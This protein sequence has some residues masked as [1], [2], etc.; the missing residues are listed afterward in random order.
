MKRLAFIFFALLALSLSAGAQ[1][2]PSKD[3][4]QELSDTIQVR[5]N[6]HFLVKNDFTFKK[7]VK[8]DKE[9]KVD[10][11]FSA[12][13][14]YFP[15]HK[16]DQSWFREMVSDELKNF[17]TDYS[18][19]SIFARNHKVTEY[20]THGIGNDG[21]PHSYRH[22]KKDPRT[23][24]IRFISQ[25]GA[26]LYPKGLTDRYIAVWQSHGLFYDDKQNFWRFQ[27]A[28]LFRTV[29]DMFTQS[30]VLPFLIPMLENSGAYVLTPRER[31]INPLEFVVDND[32]NFGSSREGMIR[33]SGTYSES[34]KWSS[35][36]EGFADYKKAYGF[37][38]KPFSAG[39]AR[40]ASCAEHPNASVTWTPEISQRGQYAVYISYKTVGNSTR[41]AHY[42]VKH[43]GGSTEF[44]VNQRRGGGTWIYLGTFE[45]DGDGSGSVTL[46]NSGN[47]GDVVTADAVR[48]GGGMGKVARGGSVSGAKSYM[49]GALYSEVWAG[50]DSAVTRS[51]TTEYID[52]YSTRGAWTSWMREEKLIPF[53]LA[54]AFHTDAGIAQNDSIIGTLAI[55]T[56]TSEGKTTFDDGRDRI[57][58]RQLC[59]FV[60]TQVVEDLRAQ[61]DPLWTR[62]GIWDKSYNESRT[63]NV[64]AMI[65]ELM[66]HQNFNDMK[67]GLDPSFRFTV[68]RAVYKGVLKT[69]SD[70]YGCAY[71][72]QPLPVNSFAV[73]F[74]GEDK[75]V[76]SWKPTEDKLEPTAEPTGYIVYTRMDDGAFDA[77]QEVEGTSIELPVREGH[78]YSYK[79][80]AFNSGGKS[81]PSEILAI[82]KPIFVRGDEVL[83]VSNFDRV[84]APS[85]VDTPDYAGFN[86]IVD[87]GVPYIR[88]I[89]FIGETYEFNPEAEYVDDDYSGFG[90]S[91]T[92]RAGEIIA[93]NTFDYPYIHGKA[94]MKLGRPFRSSSR[95]AFCAD[96]AGNATVIDLLCG[97][98]KTT[99]IGPGRVPDRYQVFPAEL[100]AAISKAAADGVNFIVN[101]ANIASDQAG[102]EVVAAFVADN[103][104]Y[105][106]A[107]AFGTRA[108]KLAGM[109]FYSKINPD[110]YCVDCPDGLNPVGKSASTWLR[111]TGSNVSAAVLFKTKTNKSVSVGLPL[112]TLMEEADRE[113]MFRSALEY[114]DRD[115]KPVNHR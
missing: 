5:L 18:L 73:R 69:L 59:D 36:G 27:R 80:E 90:A 82:G 40:M 97:K 111:Y 2:Y 51:W 115:T 28:P 1:K 55:Y 14:A 3:Q 107:S 34:G 23:G 35:A 72:V 21:N 61:F 48:F 20:S 100:R 67:L 56:R 32:K 79:V 43:L 75:A 96:G 114:F 66:S 9:K 10:L 7:A 112:E 60:Q 42:T 62:R 22:I 92:N 74:S 54:L 52:E 98:Q 65:L 113:F 38:D 76:L 105:K 16:D 47:S 71:T 26:K 25:K 24:S 41:T 86:G 39:T 12:D 83:I 64:P 95:D 37:N 87:S 45:F 33:K 91:Y 85:W 78:I 4:F 88:D 93:G 108:G 104:G 102:D 57:V 89:N 63:P 68:S 81:F 13:M 6:E 50:A 106:L 77:G 11:Y 17:T 8:N 44:N 49:E 30:F 110:F 46:D 15:W 58:S 53:D 103:F 70:F 29:E 99:T 84:S 31:D 94:L 19:G 101:G 109:P